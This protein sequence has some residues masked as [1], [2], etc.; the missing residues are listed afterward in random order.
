MTWLNWNQQ[1]SDR[2]T[3]CR[4]TPTQLGNKAYRIEDTCCVFP[5]AS[6]KTGWTIGR[7]FSTLYIPS[8]TSFWQAGFLFMCS[9]RATWQ[10]FNAYGVAF[11]NFNGLKFEVFRQEGVLATTIKSNANGW[12][13]GNIYNITIEWALSTAFYDGVYIKVRRQGLGPSQTDS[14]YVTI[15][16]VVDRQGHLTST[17][18]EGMFVNRG[19]GSGRVEFGQFQTTKGQLLGYGL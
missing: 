16:E 13:I 8:A 6:Q 19:T 18:A 5:N 2:V 10:T 17:V 9:A 14:D 15:F 7:I 1:P 3:V 11:T 12:I 4:P